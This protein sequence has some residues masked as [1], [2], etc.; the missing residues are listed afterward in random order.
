MDKK[1]LKKIKKAL[2]KIWWFIWESDSIWS[3]IVNIILAFLIIKF[4]I[5]PGLGFMLG[6]THPVVAVVSSSMEHNAVPICSASM[7]GKC[8]VY[9]KG[10][11]EICGVEINRKGFLSLDE[12]YSV[13]GDWYLDTVNITRA[14]FGEFKFKNGFNKGDIMVLVK[15]KNVRIGDVI[16]FN[17]NHRADP[18]IHRVVGITGEGFMT[19]GDHNS[20]PWDFEYI[21]P[22]ETVIGKAAV[23]VQ[24]LGWI[25]IGFM[26]LLRILGMGG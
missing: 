16:V 18:I 12:Y 15:P 22:K 7:D 25:K 17:V 9:E 19:K 11:Y 3:W 14:E 10:K 2:K 24:F 20:K 4:I 8:L 5:Y 26:N 6:T 23:R 21:V 13:C 1:Q